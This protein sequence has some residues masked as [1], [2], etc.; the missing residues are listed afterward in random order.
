MKKKYAFSSV[1]AGDPEASR[2]QAH[3]GKDLKM[4]S[5][6]FFFKTVFAFFE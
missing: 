6:W 1:T 3:P 5:S 4:A 2:C